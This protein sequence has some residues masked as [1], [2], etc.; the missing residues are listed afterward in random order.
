MNQVLSK[1]VTHGTD[2]HLHIYVYRYAYQCVFIDRT[3]IFILRYSSD[4]YNSPMNKQDIIIISLISEI[5]NEGSERVQLH[6]I[7]MHR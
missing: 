4:P 3:Y 7:Y 1:H 5:G 6:T 2:I